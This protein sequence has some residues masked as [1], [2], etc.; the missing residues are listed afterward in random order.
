MI[1]PPD[2]K[3]SIHFKSDPPNKVTLLTKLSN[4]TSIKYN[5]SLRPKTVY[6]VK[7]SIKPLFNTV[8]YK[9]GSIVIGSS[10]LLNL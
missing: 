1:T 6:L 3:V 5:L 8:P 7:P 2:N 4:E 9:L 10:I